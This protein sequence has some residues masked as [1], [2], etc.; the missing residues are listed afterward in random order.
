MLSLTLTEGNMHFTKLK[1]TLNTSANTATM[2]NTQVTSKNLVYMQYM[3]T[4][5]SDP[6]NHKSAFGSEKAV[7]VC[8]LLT[9]SSGE[10]RGMR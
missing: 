8:K 3:I 7:S 1:Y 5:F 2:Y 4:L 9:T 10:F 6:M